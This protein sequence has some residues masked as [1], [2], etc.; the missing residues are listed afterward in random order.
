[1]SFTVASGGTGGDG[2]DTGGDDGGVNS[3]P[4]AGADSATTM[5]GQPVVIGVLTNDTDADGDQLSI[6]GTSN[7]TNGQIVVNANGT[8]TYTPRS[9][10]SG[11]DSF[12]YRVSDGE[13]VS[14]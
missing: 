7:P 1:M 2:G 14:N 8:I 10:F 6:A 5:A 12:S 13:L 9:G 4:V 3:A 11:L